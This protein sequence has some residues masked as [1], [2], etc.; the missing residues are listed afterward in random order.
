MGGS[1]LATIT[2]FGGISGAGGL[3]FFAFLGSSVGPHPTQM[4]S[5]FLDLINGT[6]QSRY[7]KSI[8]KELIV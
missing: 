4:H 8:Q 5:P 1:R 2:L 3:E 6:R 7:K